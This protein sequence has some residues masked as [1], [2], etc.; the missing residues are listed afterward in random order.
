MGFAWCVR[1][2]A[3]RLASVYGGRLGQFRSIS[4]V[5]NRPCLARNPSPIPPFV[6]HGFL[7]STAIDRMSSEQTLLRIIDSE[8]NS[9][10]EIDDR[11]LVSFIMRKLKLVCNKTITLLC[12]DEIKEVFVLNTEMGVGNFATCFSFL[13]CLGMVCANGL[14]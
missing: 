9:A 1:R 4:A 3:S 14:I 7:Y 11:D 12:F 13:I 10:R 2:S 8:I 5:V 6:S